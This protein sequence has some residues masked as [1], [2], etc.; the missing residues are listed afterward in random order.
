MAKGGLQPFPLR[1]FLLC[2]GSRSSLVSK[3]VLDNR[4]VT[5]DVIG[6]RAQQGQHIGALVLESRTYQIIISIIFPLT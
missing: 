4:L 1:L 5:S 3:Y 2:D 6:T